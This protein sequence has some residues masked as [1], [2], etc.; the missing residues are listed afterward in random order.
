[1]VAK[2]HD[3][4]MISLYE[5]AICPHSLSCYLCAICSSGFKRAIPP[6]VKSYKNCLLLVLESNDVVNL[7]ESEH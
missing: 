3:L 7:K 2:K 5:H 1:M 4:N 6:D